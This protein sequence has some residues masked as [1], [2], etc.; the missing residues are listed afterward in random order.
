MD[1][2]IVSRQPIGVYQPLLPTPETPQV[3]LICLFHCKFT[4]IWQTSTFFY[5]AHIL[6]GQVNTDPAVSQTREFAWLTKQEIEGRLDRDYWL[7]VKDMLS[8]F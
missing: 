4:Y 8:D 5:K 3:S 1:T 7:G 6:A 2:W